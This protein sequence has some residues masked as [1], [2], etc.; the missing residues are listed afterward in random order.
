GYGEAAAF[1]AEGKTAIDGEMPTNPTGGLIGFGHYTGG[2][3]VRQAV[4]LVHQLTGK[5]SD[6]QVDIK[7]ER[8]Y[9]MLISMGGND[10][11]VTCMIFRKAT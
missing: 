8:P 2:T 6:C 3:G 11:T 9:G 4:D 10:R 1:V 5:A 7:S